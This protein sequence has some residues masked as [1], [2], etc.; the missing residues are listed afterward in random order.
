MGTPQRLLCC[1]FA[2]MLSSTGWA[3]IGD[4]L[5]E[6]VQRYGQ[7]LNKYP[8]DGFIDSGCRWIISEYSATGTKTKKWL[9]VVFASFVDGEVVSLVIGKRD[10][11]ASFVPCT[12]KE[13]QA[14]LENN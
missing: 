4:T 13:I 7:P 9:F 3:R 2:V 5:Q 12:P 6:C 14:L 10:A 11:E 8:R 1:A